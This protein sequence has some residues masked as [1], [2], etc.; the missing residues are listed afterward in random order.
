VPRLSRAE[1]RVRTRERV[2][3]A[4]AEVFTH[5]GF[6]GASLD[7]IAEAAG[8]SR[9]A[10]YS[11][12]SDKTELF[13]AVRDERMLLRR[14][15]VG[16]LLGA[17]RTPADFFDALRD[18]NRLQSRDDVRKWYMLQ[19]ELW[20]YAMRNP[21]VRPLLAERESANRAA[22]GEAIEALY[23]SLD[24]RPPI[25]AN[26]LAIIVE[27]IDRGLPF[28]EFLDPEAVPSEFV[29]RAMQFLLEAGVALARAP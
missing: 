17:A 8:Y 15:Q 10:V 27:A 26:E 24:V 9:G 5:K 16:D 18:L 7:E 19:L 23:A 28:Q 13:L 14:Q 29:I 22:L 12:F 2:I 1:S 21:D 25:P 20:L 6:H 4:A 11:N 3:A